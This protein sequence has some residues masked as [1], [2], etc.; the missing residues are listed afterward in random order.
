VRS[1]R[2]FL[3]WPLLRR[4]GLTFD[5][6]LVLAHFMLWFQDPT[7]NLTGIQLYYS[8]Q[9]MNR[10]RGRW[11]RAETVAGRPFASL[12]VR[13]FNYQSG[14]V[15]NGIGGYVEPGVPVSPLLLPVRQN[16]I[17][18]RAITPRHGGKPGNAGEEQPGRKARARTDPH[19]WRYWSRLP[20]RHGVIGLR[21]V[22]E[23]PDGPGG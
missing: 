4:R 7:G 14:A 23:M 12:S 18:R 9:W 11:G 2:P 10:V 8:S 16:G 15:G 13:S 19:L 3:L 5:G 22:D 1:S 6:M 21:Q 20:P 17:Q